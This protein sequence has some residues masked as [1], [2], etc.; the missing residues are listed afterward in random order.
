MAS[1][2]WAKFLRSCAKN[3][4]I[5][6][7]PHTKVFCGGVWGGAV[8]KKY[9]PETNEKEQNYDNQTNYPLP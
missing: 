8:C 9:L 3:L 5:L 2:Q 6:N 1:V 4:N 7:L